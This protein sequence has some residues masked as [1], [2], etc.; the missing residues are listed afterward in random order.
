MGKVVLLDGSQMFRGPL[1]SAKTDDLEYGFCRDCQTIRYAPELEFTP[2]GITCTQCGE[3]DVELPRWVDCPH[4]RGAVKCAFGGSG[5]T[6]GKAGYECRDRC[7]F[8]F[9]ESER[10]ESK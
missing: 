8:F 7:R 9:C 1:S 2:H 6:R 5:L 10:F 3:H 4:R